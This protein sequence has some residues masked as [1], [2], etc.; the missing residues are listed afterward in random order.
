MII[1]KY[2]KIG[3]L[4]QQTGLTVRALHHYDQIDLFSSSDVTESGHRIYTEADVAKLQ[5]ILSLKQLGFSLEEIKATIEDPNF[6]PVEVIKVQL[7]TVKKQIMVQEQLYT[8]LEGMYELLADQQEVQSEQFIKLIE[9][10]NMSEKYFT[11]E[12]LD[13]MKNQT[14]QFSIEE[15]R[16]VENEWTELIAAIR[17]ELKKGTPPEN[18]NMVRLAAQWQELTNKFTGGDSE[19]ARAAERFHTDNPNN[20]LQYG[21]DEELYKYISKAMIH[22]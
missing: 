3:E 6:N 20:P 4:A 18:P 19:I 22:I 12:Q 5:Q 1:N 9:V 17:V 2:W 11:K 16:Q 10:M 8:R 14:N 13:K 21:V 15:K 7:E